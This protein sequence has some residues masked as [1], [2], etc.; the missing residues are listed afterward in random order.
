MESPL[1]KPG[2][3]HNEAQRL[4]ALR[5]LKILDT[6]A[7]EHFD[8][9]TRMARRMFDVPVALISFVDADR[10]WFKSRQGLIA[11]ETPRDLSF[12]AHAILSEET[13]VVEDAL[14]DE[15][16]A[17]NPLVTADPKIRF[18][19]GHP[20][21]APDGMRLGTLC[22]I[23]FL[24]RRFPDAD[25]AVL[26]DL[27]ELVEREMFAYALSTSDE[28]TGIANLAGFRAVAEHALA[29]CRRLDR[30]A[31]LARFRLDKL[32]QPRG[33]RDPASQQ[34]SIA[35]FAQCLLETCRYSDVIGRTGEH[36]FCALLADADAGEASATLE[37]L[38]RNVAA[39]NA[40][41][42][43]DELRYSTGLANFNGALH[44]SLDAVLHEAEEDLY[45]SQRHAAP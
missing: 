25:R 10:Q 44:E 1:V 39:S 15:R 20:I 22:V 23:D 6:E 8:R 27:C 9:I 16:F 42:H 35:E 40:R 17:A 34:R 13:L 41:R 37:R 24:P 36:E 26:V 31:V 30:P 3:P 5:S 4:L 12:C 19:A 28:L 18:Y 21:T 29:L 2:T 32:A 45:R 14:E 33:P 11:S 7:E 38:A 43:G